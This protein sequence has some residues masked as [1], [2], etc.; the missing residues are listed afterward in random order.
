[1]IDSFELADA[2]DVISY[3]ANL[4]SGAFSGMS[5][6]DY[7]LWKKNHGLSTAYAL[8]KRDH[9][10]GSL[11][12]ENWEFYPGNSIPKKG[13]LTSKAY[14]RYGLY[15]LDVTVFLGQRKHSI[16]YSYGDVELDQTGNI[17]S[18]W[19]HVR[20]SHS[21]PSGRC[22][23]WFDAKAS[24]SVY[25]KDR[26]LSDLKQFTGASLLGCLNGQFGVP[27]SEASFDSNGEVSTLTI[28]T[29]GGAVLDPSLKFKVELVREDGSRKMYESGD[30]LTIKNGVVADA[31]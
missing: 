30:K 27:V 21:T 31:R 5:F 23:L 18:L 1:M 6:N 2:N 29:P 20:S 13:S 16:T 28:A 26:I 9:Y 15:G 24:G 7:Y 19:G 4:V 14:S 12:M 8:N 25:L 3:V 22:S 17:K 10:W 11:E